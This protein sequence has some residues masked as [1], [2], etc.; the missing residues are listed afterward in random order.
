MRPLRT[1]PPARPRPK[2]VAMIAHTYYVRDPRVRRAAET[3]RAGGYEVDV[4]CLRDP[5]LAE[6]PREVVNGVRVIR[7][8]LARRRGAKSRYL[9]EYGAFSTMA[10]ATVS[11]YHLARRYDLIHCHTHP[12]PIVFAAALPRLLGARVLLDMHD[13]MPETLVSKYHVPMRHPLVRLSVVL[14]QASIRFAHR[15]LTVHEPLRQV[16]LGRGA[17][18]ARMGV[19]MNLTDPA[20]FA[21]REELP[22]PARGRFIVIYAGTVAERYGLDLAVRAVAAL[23][24]AIPG[25]LLRLVGDGDQVPELRRLVRALG[26]EDL[27]QFV[28]PVPNTEVRRMLQDADIGISPHR[29]DILFRLSLSH[30]IYE[31]VATGVPAVVPRTETLQRYY[32]EDVAAFFIPG[33]ADDLARTI[34]RLYRSPAERRARVEAGWRLVQRWNWR[35]E[36]QALL[37]LVEHTITGVP[38]PVPDAARQTDT[39]S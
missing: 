30:K 33:D 22:D 8:P 35:E 38:E 20:L 17:P 31:Y 37:C 5:E 24:D 3:L 13:P 11:G 15:A 21:R 12:D 18:P 32:P 23:R 36:R 26:V 19:V 39:R 28:G 4:F 16:F 7:L 29:P 1:T 6:S 9:F 14:E 10:A 27:V 2:R 34:L 25:L